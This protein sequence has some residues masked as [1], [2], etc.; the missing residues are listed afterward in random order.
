MAFSIFRHSAII[1]ALFCGGLAAF[2]TSGC[3]PVVDRPVA[4]VAPIPLDAMVVDFPVG[5]YGA[6][7]VET[8]PGDLATLNPLVN[9]SAA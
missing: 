3:D 4:A 8:I 1:R 9:E 7:V 5:E 6:N 2:V